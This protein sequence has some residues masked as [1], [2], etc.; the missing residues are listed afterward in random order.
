MRKCLELPEVLSPKVQRFLGRRYQFRHGYYSTGW[1]RG[2]GLKPFYTAL[3]RDVWEYFS[4]EEIPDGFCIHHEDGDKANNEYANLICVDHGEHM[5]YHSNYVGGDK[6]WAKLDAEG[7]KARA[8]K[9]REGIKKRDS[10]WH[11]SPEGRAHHRRVWLEVVSPK[12]N[13][14]V[15]IECACCSVVFV[16]VARSKFC[17]ECSAHRRRT[18]WTDCKQCGVRFRGSKKRVYCSDECKAAFKSKS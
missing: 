9:I 15:D 6:G 7:H 18:K 3:H 8:D 12:L 16:G 10:S 17:S 2:P 5:S 13:A 4:G 1:S 14:P 11:R